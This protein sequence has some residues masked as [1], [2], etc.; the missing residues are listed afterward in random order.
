ML[1]AI[2]ESMSKL[3]EDAAER[4]AER[5]RAKEE[6]DDAPPP[7]A[8]AEEIASFFG[9]ELASNPESDTPIEKEG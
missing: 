4:R 2:A 7:N 1:K 8:T 6:E 9:V 3:E 5:E